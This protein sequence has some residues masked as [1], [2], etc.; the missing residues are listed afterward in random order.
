MDIRGARVV[1]MGTPEFAVPTLRRLASLCDVALVI[2]QPD[3]PAGRGRTLT[4]PP[5]K[6]AAMEFGIPVL[7]PRRVREPEV[8]DAV[9]RLAP[10]VAVTAA[11]GQLL[12][13][14]LLDIPR[15]G[16]LNVHASLLPRWRGAAPI[17][18]AVMAG[19]SET[20]VTLMR[21]VQALDAGPVLGMRRLPIGPDDNTGVIH[22]RLAALG[23]ELVAELLPPYLAGELEPVPQPEEGVTYAE[24]IRPEDEWIHW[25]RPAAQVH[26]HVRGLCPWPGASTLVNGER[27]KVWRTARSVVTP[28]E[29]APPGTVVAQGDGVFAACGD[30]W[31]RLEEV[32]PAGR[33]RMTAVDWWRGLRRDSL[34]LELPE[35][36]VSL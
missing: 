22:D 10:D 18:R 27:L 4:P 19:D 20:G 21:M 6:V 26:N 24:R 36:E 35:G 15:R 3:K 11:Y 13:Q 25:D 8:L 33:R 2:T 14:A 16:C 9:A 12:P 28:G 1:F 7:Q 30:G 29:T 34:V 17:H 32:Q 5:V 23:A 31:L